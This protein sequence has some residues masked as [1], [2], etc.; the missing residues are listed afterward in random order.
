MSLDLLDGISGHFRL[1]ANSWRNAQ[2]LPEADLKFCAAGN[3]M[4][5]VSVKFAGQQKWRKDRIW[6][7]PRSPMGSRAN[8]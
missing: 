8:P 1:L 3:V 5:A 6:D 4:F 7:S 2:S